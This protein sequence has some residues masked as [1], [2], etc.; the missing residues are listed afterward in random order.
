MKHLLAL[1]SVAALALFSAPSCSLTPEQQ[2]KVMAFTDLGVQAFVDNGVL[3]P[4]TSVLIKS[5]VGLVTSFKAPPKEVPLHQLGLT[6]A[7]VEGVVKTGDKVVIGTDEA[8]VI[9][10][11][12]PIALGQRV[13]LSPPA[14]P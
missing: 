14:S 3:K 7:V 13:G 6:E 8:L 12:E 11:P 9:S 10:P 1:S 2:A 5:G 4:G